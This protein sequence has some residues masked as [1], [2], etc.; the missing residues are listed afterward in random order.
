MTSRLRWSSTTR[1]T[2]ACDRR[3]AS[4]PRSSKSCTSSTNWERRWVY[5]ICTSHS[6][7][8][9]WQLLKLK[10]LLLSVGYTHQHI[11]KVVKHKDLQQQLVDAKL[12]QAQ[13]LLKESEERHDKE[14]D[15]VIIFFTY[16]KKKIRFAHVTSR[17]L[18]FI[19]SC[20]KK[21]WSLK[22]PVSWWSSRR[23]TSNSRSSHPSLTTLTAFYTFKMLVLYQVVFFSL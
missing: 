18:C 22:G 16:A 13:E 10:C 15:F 19:L 11:D 23:S 1:E 8:N 9:T 20:W 14:K 6:R 7:W 5:F 17:V 2:P 4:W 21:R 3:T 12:Y